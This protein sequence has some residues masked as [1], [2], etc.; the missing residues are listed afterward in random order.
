MNSTFNANIYVRN[1]PRNVTEEQFQ[2]TMSK[3]G[4]IISL[5]IKEN[6]VTADGG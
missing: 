2:D 6:T 3:A 1:I 4:K 5:K